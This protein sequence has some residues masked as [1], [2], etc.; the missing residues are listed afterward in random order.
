MNQRSSLSI[1][2]YSFYFILLL[3]TLMLYGCG[4]NTNATEKS[5]AQPQE[6]TT[7]P[8]GSTPPDSTTTP[9]GSTPP[10]VITP[11]SNHEPTANIQAPADLTSGE[12][13]S[14]DGSHSSDPDGDT[15]SYQWIQTAGPDITLTDSSNSSLTIVAPSVIQPTQITFQ[16]TVHD[17]EASNKISA[18]ILISPIADNSAPSIVSR[19]PQADQTEVSSTAEIVVSFNEALL[20]S[21]IDS[22][23]LVVTQDNTPVPGNVSYDSNSYSLRFMPTSA[24]SA[25]ISYTATLAHSLTDVAGNAFA[26]ASWSF[27]T[28]V[29]ATA[30]EESDLT[31]SCPSGK[32][33]ND[34]SFASYG[35]PEGSCGSFS[36]GS[37][38][39]SS[40]LTVVSDACKG[41]DSCTLKA[42]N[43]TFGDP[44]SG[45]AKHL[46]AQVSCGMPAPP[47]D[48][49]KSVDLQAAVSGTSVTLS[50]SLTGID[51]YAQAIMRD[52]DP[53]PAGRV[54]IGYA[55]N[56]SNEYIDQNLTPGETYYYWVKVTDVDSGITNSKTTAATIAARPATQPFGIGRLVTGGAGGTTVR[57]STMAE[58]AQALC[59]STSGG[60][61]SDNTPRII[62]VASTIDMTDADGSG[63]SQ[64]CNAVNVC[65]ATMKSEVTLKLTSNITHCDGKTLFD[66][67]YKKAALNPL[68]VGS[69]KTLI[70]IG[71]NGVLKGKGL[72]LNGVSNVIIRNLSFTDIGHGLVFGGDAVNVAR[73]SKVWIDHNYFSR[74]GRQMIVS[75]SGDLTAEVTDMTVS[76]NEF[77]GRNDYSPY[78]NGHHYWNLLFYGKGNFT[79][80]NNYVH[81]F[82]GRAPAINSNVIVHLVNNYF[83]DG[84]GHALDPHNNVHALVEGND[85]KNVTTPVT[86]ADTQLYGLLS[87]SSSS[88]TACQNALG[89]KCELNQINPVP[90]STAP[91]TQDS[92]ILDAF[93]ASIPDAAIVIPIPVKDVSST[94]LS[95][96]GVGKI[97]TQW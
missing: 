52:T 11:I 40:S 37:C 7:A 92:S 47:V 94:V 53:D 27:T 42:D 18:N 57:V 78:C 39:S 88:D 54:K 86:D 76:W 34:V 12:T 62:E 83:E 91:F 55:T 22:Q 46:S 25:G 19:S 80:A 95:G 77:D 59:D 66:V 65:P 28:G 14:L 45:T 48:A 79:F 17:G 60:Y 85:F 58:L 38:D 90:A 35:T 20:E 15:L 41:L 30:G 73:A 84:A 23:S 36:K 72:R 51:P 61:C 10:D 75:G 56:G 44:C 67:S 31:L 82:S 50:W 16:L 2:P 9:D 63:T 97:E 69:N 21:S 93:S 8:G 6:S 33:I 71:K 74:I 26:G 13:G 64:A 32:V 3:T 96:A 49:V 43:A 1:S 29:C 87:P 4:S 81:D 24:L 89:R 70:G 68:T 5:D